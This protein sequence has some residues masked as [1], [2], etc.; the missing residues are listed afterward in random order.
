MTVAKLRPY[1]LRIWLL[2][3][4]H[5]KST[6]DLIDF[7]LGGMRA[8]LDKRGPMTPLSFACCY[9]EHTSKYPRHR[10]RM[11]PG[12]PP[13]W[14]LDFVV[15]EPDDEQ[16]WADKLARL[17]D[18]NG[19]HVVVAEVLESAGDGTWGARYRPADVRKGLTEGHLFVIDKDGRRSTVQVVRPS[20]SEAGTRA[21]GAVKL[22]A[23][24]HGMLSELLI[25]DA[26]L[27]FRAVDQ[28][29]VLG[30]LRIRAEE[31]G[32]RMNLAPGTPLIFASPVPGCPV[33]VYVTEEGLTGGTDP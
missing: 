13:L 21:E 24:V 28:A 8:H 20:K 6:N 31:P 7:I 9:P 26:G 29:P 12:H 23:N 17:F 27:H 22:R 18:K 4:E 25:S 16:S 14:S 5:E 30:R 10:L 32:A 1:R 3:P 19:W 11:H 15:V 33:T 2:D